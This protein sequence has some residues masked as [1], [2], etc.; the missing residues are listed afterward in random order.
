MI[1]DSISRA[2]LVPFKAFRG[3]LFPKPVIG[4]ELFFYVSYSKLALNKKGP[5]AQICFS[6]KSYLKDNTFKKFMM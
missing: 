5:N 2:G 3:P 6:Q 1:G 4:Q